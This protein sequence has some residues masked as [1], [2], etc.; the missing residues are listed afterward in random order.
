MGT[1]EAV[2]A[3]RAVAIA[4]SGWLQGAAAATDNLKLALSARRA[5]DL[6]RD[7]LRAD[8]QPTRDAVSGP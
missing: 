4:I 1:D 5:R 3:D 7:Y 8:D 6:L 2:P